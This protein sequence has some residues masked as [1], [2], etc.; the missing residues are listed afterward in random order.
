MPL[1]LRRVKDAVADE[2]RVVAEQ[3]GLN[4]PPDAAPAGH[5]LLGDAE[6]L[7]VLD[8]LRARKAELDAQHARQPLQADTEPQ[9]RRAHELERTLREV[10]ERIKTFSHSRVL[11]KL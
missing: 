10:E 11:V 2:Q 3:L 9:R 4:R 5:R 1:Y 7:E 8:G 6:R